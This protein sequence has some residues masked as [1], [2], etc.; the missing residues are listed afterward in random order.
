[1][2]S[3]PARLPG[4]LQI[5]GKL[6]ISCES[7]SFALSF[8]DDRIVLDADSFGSLFKLRKEAESL[9]SLP[10]S[11]IS[12]QRSEKGKR[13]S[14]IPKQGILV[15]VKGRPAGNIVETDSGMGFRPTPLQFLKNLF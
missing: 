15:T 9:L 11:T 6:S 8:I 4:G 13:P 14:F 7:S 1:M 5:T 2:S 10:Q 12:V 3:E